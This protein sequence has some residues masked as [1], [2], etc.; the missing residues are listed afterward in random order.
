MVI[1]TCLGNLRMEI[2][3]IQINKIYLV[4]K[5]FLTLEQRAEIIG[6]VNMGLKLRRRTHHCGCFEGC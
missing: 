4:I 2:V 6:G 1:P 3:I 5:I